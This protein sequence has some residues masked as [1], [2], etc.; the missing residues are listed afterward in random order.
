MKVRRSSWHN[1]LP[2]TR[3]ERV[4]VRGFGLQSKDFDFRTPSSCPSPLWGEGTQ[5][6]GR[7]I[8]LPAWR[9][10]RPRLEHRLDRDMRPRRNLVAERHVGIVH[11]ARLVAL[12]GKLAEHIA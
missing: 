6:A 8:T 4:G 2:L 7:S 3:G 9:L 11:L 10:L 1:E 12:G 5:R